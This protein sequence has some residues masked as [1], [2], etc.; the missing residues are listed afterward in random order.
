MRILMRMALLV[1]LFVTTYSQASFR[2]L[3][4]SYSL[5]WYNQCVRYSANNATPEKELT[6]CR[7]MAAASKEI[8]CSLYVDLPLFSQDANTG[9]ALAMV[10][11][12]NSKKTYNLATLSGV[13]YTNIDCPENTSV[14]GAFIFQAGEQTDNNSG[15][16]YHFSFP[17][18]A[19]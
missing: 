8:S 14:D 12:N 10:S 3:E 15:K 5:D 1:P 18:M 11:W 13:Y 6:F 4:P 17:A 7:T 2:S 16:Q 9:S 19:N